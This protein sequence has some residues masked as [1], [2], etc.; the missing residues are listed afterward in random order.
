MSEIPDLS[1]G[2]LAYN[3]ETRI[4]ATLQG[5]FAQDVFVRYS[6]EVVVIA[7]GCTDNTASIA[8]DTILD[9]QALWSVRGSTRVVE[10]T[11]AGKSNAWNKFV[12]EFS[13]PRAA[14][15]FLMDSDI[16][17]ISAGT[18]NSMLTTLNTNREAVVCVDRPVKDIAQIPNP[19]FVQRLL[20]ASTPKI[21]PND[22]A[23][24]GQLY[25]VRSEELR[26]IKLP[27]D[28]TVED[29]FLRALLLTYGFTRPEDR[30]RIILDLK[31]SHIFKSVATLRETFKHEVRVVAGS[32]VNMLL[33][34][35]FSDECKLDRS[36]M[37]LMQIWERE[38]PGWLKVF[39]KHKVE[40][41]GWQ[42]LP[43]SWW[44]RRWSRLGQMPFPKMLGRAP[45][46]ALASALDM[47]VFLTAIR[48]VRNGK[49]L[50]Y[51]GR[52]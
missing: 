37:A 31:A 2:I 20:L 49:A 5:L 40:E 14:V 18:L 17:L 42:L 39:V 41:R 10:L 35:R 11:E 3:E 9:N 4:G 26:A 25:C 7:N 15:L 22:P 51:W 30:R 32:I 21:D 29:G 38:N 36:A 47:V 8:R 28:I 33:F 13:S 52:A 43:S 27:V 44:T 19:T 16:E 1:I 6:T 34:E 48:Y 50:G 46:V 45:G 12:H 24:C 23:L